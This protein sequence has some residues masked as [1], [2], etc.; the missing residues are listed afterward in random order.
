MS[1]NVTL[2][3]PN[4]VAI[5][6]QYRGQL[7][8]MP[9]SK[10]RWFLYE[11]EQAE[12]SA[13]S[14]IL[15]PAAR[16]MRAARKDGTYAG[17]RSTRTDG[18]VRLPK[19]FRGN[20]KLIQELEHGH[21]NARSIF[22]E[23]FPPAELALMVGDGIELGVAVGEMLPVPGRDFPVLCRLDPEWL[24]YRW[25]DNQWLYQSIAGLIPITPG[26]GRW[27]LHVPGGRYAP[28]HSGMWR[29]IGSAFI[30]KEAAKMHKSNWEG[31][32]ANPARVALAPIG[33]TE[34]QQESWFQQVMRW[35]VNTVFSMKP[36]YDVKLIE[37]NG[38]GFESFLQTIDRA[39]ND[40]II[41]MCGQIVM[42]TGGSGF[43]NG[44][45]YKSVTTD[46]IKSTA[47]S[48]AY[49]I[50]TQGLPQW[51][52]AKYGEEILNDLAIVEWDVMPPS[53]RQ[54]EATAMSTVG[55]ALS[56]LLDSFG[57]TGVQID[58]EAFAAKF[59]VPVKKIED[60]NAKPFYNYHLEAGIIKVDEMRERI[61]LEPIGGEEGERLIGEEDPNE[62]QSS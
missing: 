61:G 13:D 20:Q 19:R 48:L 33:A 10:T 52:V 54:L 44:D 45:I 60:S 36:G 46:L 12:H 55:Q 47:D 62:V 24:Q 31:K 16:L 4:V 7:S 21:T 37:S 29:A 15:G 49:T 59:G 39:N 11:L 2:D 40:M 17:V 34:V 28:W 22:D 9:T 25:S 23:M 56:S 42:T 51:S 26:D 6:E 8:P 14:G 53:D 41:A 5:R 35:G 18:L 43:V 58:V 50:N 57:S 1:S 27:V 32:L 30:D 3:S 38:R